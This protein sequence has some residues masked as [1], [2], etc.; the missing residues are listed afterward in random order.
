MW[1]IIPIR[2][3]S[4]S[5]SAMCCAAGPSTPDQLA[6]V[7][8][9]GDGDLEFYGKDNIAV[10]RIGRPLPM[11]WALHDLG[12]ENHRTR[13]ADVWPPGSPRLPANQVE[14]YVL[15]NCGARP[16]DRDHDDVRLIADVAEG[17]GEIVNSE[18]DIQGYPVE[19]P[20]HR[21]FNP[22]DWNLADMTPRSANALDSANKSRGT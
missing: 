3:A 4:L 20:T 7:E 22:A 9:G 21:A 15:A 6:F 11:F 16:W 12:R 8:I 5:P 14:L 19:T 18:S 1:A 2:T 13:Y 10:D 17:R